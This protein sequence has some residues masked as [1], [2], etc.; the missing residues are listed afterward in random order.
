MPQEI[1]QELTRGKSIF[2]FLKS[3]QSKATNIYIYLKVTVSLGGSFIILVH[4]SSKLGKMKPINLAITFQMG[5]KHA[6]Q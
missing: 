4:F 1:K 5:E 6:N 2:G 3:E